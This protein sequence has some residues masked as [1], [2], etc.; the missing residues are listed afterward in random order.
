MTN[1]DVILGMNWLA[2]NHASIDYHKKEVIFSSL[3]GPNFKFKGTCIGTTP[4]VVSM[5]KVKRLFQQGD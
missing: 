4:K 3:L 1:F 2:E 5:M